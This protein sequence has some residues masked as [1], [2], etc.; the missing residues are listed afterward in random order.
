MTAW[1]D[2]LTVVRPHT[3]QSADTVPRRQMVGR[4]RRQS[5]APHVTVSG[6]EKAGYRGEALEPDTDCLGPTGTGDQ[7]HSQVFGGHFSTS[8]IPL[9]TAAR[10][11]HAL[12]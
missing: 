10:Y 5:A 1:P 2:R 11:C 3:R 9:Q 12:A 6:R 4:W 7:L 8:F